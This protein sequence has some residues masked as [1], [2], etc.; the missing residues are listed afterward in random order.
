MTAWRLTMEGTGQAIG[1][2]LDETLYV[3]H[4]DDILTGF[5]ATENTGGGGLLKISGSNVAQGARS[6]SLQ[7]TAAI[8]TY[9]EADDSL[10]GATRWYSTYLYMPTA[11]GA[12]LSNWEI[13]QCRDTGTRNRCRIQTSR[14]LAVVGP[15][16]VAG[17]VAL[18]FD[19]LIRLVYKV[20]YSAAA[21]ELTA[22]AYT[23]HTATVIDTVSSTG[24]ATGAAVGTNTRWGIP[25]QAG[26]TAGPWFMDDFRIS[27]VGDPGPSGA[28]GGVS[29]GVPGRVKRW[30]GSAWVS[31]LKVSRW[32]GTVWETVK[33]RPYD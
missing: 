1:D 32:T 19:T 25:I 23:G 6:L 31:D 16:T 33:V 4:A 10:F 7:T 30:D 22:T 21:G 24:I 3:G 12:P 15:S 5:N 8:S 29:Q 28:T 17:T 20:I 18:P 26:A 9:V 27:D 2:T 14:I 11:S 13:I